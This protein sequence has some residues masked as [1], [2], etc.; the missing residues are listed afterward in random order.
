MNANL[1]A[2]ETQ[3]NQNV[4]FE[5]LSIDQFK[6]RPPV[7]WVVKNLLPDQG[8]A[9]MY[10]QSGTGKTFMLLDLLLAIANGDDWFGH[11]T[12]KTP[13]CYVCLEGVSGIS[14]R[15][16]AWEIA[17]GKSVPDNFRI[18]TNSFILGN[19]KDVLDLAI[20]IQDGG[21]SNG[22]IA[23]DTLNAA[24]P[25]ME[26][27]S[28]K[29]MGAAIENLRLLQ[30]QTNGLVMTTHHTGKDETR[31]M[32][33]H[34]SLHGAIDVE[35]YLKGTKTNRSWILQKIRDYEN[36]ETHGFTLVVHELDTDEDG[37][38]ITSCSIGSDALPFS[39][40]RKPS[41]CNQLLV[42][43][44]ICR[45]IEEESK[46]AGHPVGVAYEIVIENAAIALS[47][48]DSH[49]RKYNAE[50]IVPNLIAQHFF[51]CRIDNGK[52]FITLI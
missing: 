25:T 18:I 30:R 39:G 20:S 36:G 12:T 42:F 32:R 33:G 48:L 23:I 34:S 10:G 16:A 8:L 14:Q 46:I 41:G 50:K 52:E 28:S 26:E 43:N 24:T 1:N 38:I 22:V 47:K 15:I 13:V 19:R 27:N 7:R 40:I 44:Q 29:E 35:I 2:T 51:E 6:K 11:A 4:R 17:T 49:K 9:I 5:L 21:F 37:E 31:G 3:V 45:L